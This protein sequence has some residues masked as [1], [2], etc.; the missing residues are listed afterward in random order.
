MENLDKAIAAYD[1]YCEQLSAG[2]LNAPFEN[3]LMGSISLSDSSIAMPCLAPG[4]L[5]YFKQLMAKME[6]YAQSFG[7]QRFEISE[8]IRRFPEVNECMDFLELWRHEAFH[9]IQKHAYHA[10]FRLVDA[11]QKIESWELTIFF[12]HATSGGQWKLG[13]GFLSVLR[14]HDE[15]II[16]HLAPHVQRECQVVLSALRK[17]NHG[18]GLFDLIE[19]QAFIA[20]RAATGLLS[21]RPMPERPVYVR[22]WNRFL[23]CGG[24]DPVVFV[25]L[26][27]AALRY[28][29]ISDDPGSDFDDFHPHPV[30]VF[31]YLLNFA[32][33]FEA[34][35]D[36]VDRN[37]SFLGRRFGLFGSKLALSEQPELPSP[38]FERLMDKVIGSG[39]KPVDSADKLMSYVRCKMTS[40]EQSS[41]TPSQSQEKAWYFHHCRRCNADGGYLQVDPDCRKCSG[42]GEDWAEDEDGREWLARIYGAEPMSGI[43]PTFN[44]FGKRIFTDGE[45]SDTYEFEQESAER[46]AKLH[47]TI[48]KAFDNLD[49]QPTSNEMGAAIEAG[50]KLSK[51]IATVLEKAYHR[52][53]PSMKDELPRGSDSKI[54]D[55][56]AND[57]IDV[58]PDF[59][60]EG[61]IIRSLLDQDFVIG[62]LFP[63]FLFVMNEQVMVKPFHSRPAMSHGQYL[64]MRLMPEA[65]KKLLMVYKWRTGKTDANPVQGPYCCERHGVLPSAYSSPDILDDCTSEDSTAKGF[66]I[67]F[68]K[69]LQSMFAKGEGDEGHFELCC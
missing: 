10:V 36:A 1:A 26:V 49:D 53:A 22:A 28:G 59:Y 9:G 30:D 38:E 18:I 48:W 8:L 35:F 12:L 69:P 60:R 45:E 63:Y 68:G 15:S 57:Y 42:T 2:F 61:M 55:A 43:P 11:I 44:R 13:E 17:N 27:G 4:F 54:A 14:S 50:L 29:D 67:L 20:A 64:S 40:S 65:V 51:A 6:G 23:A 66:E 47:A 62:K 3:G 41:P 31:D 21:E 19:G 39:I 16:D 56:V 33:E 52:L 34:L 7:N 58:F 32:A 5:A 24:R 37:P 25:L 46:D